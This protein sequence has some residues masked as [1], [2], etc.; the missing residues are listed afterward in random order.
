MR[1]LNSDNP[2]LVEVSEVIDQGSTNLA[3]LSFSVG[4]AGK[5][6]AAGTNSC[7]SIAASALDGLHAASSAAKPDDAS[8]NMSGL[9]AD[10]ASDTLALISDGEPDEEE[11]NDNDSAA[12]STGKDSSTEGDV[13]AT[14]EVL[15]ADLIEMKTLRTTT[16][17]HDDW[18]HRG[19]YLHDLSYHTYTEYIDRM[20]L[21]QQA[22]LEEQIFRFES[23]YVLFRSYGQRIKT[24]ARTPVMEALKFVPPGGSTKEENA[25]YKLLIGSPLRCACAECTAVLPRPSAS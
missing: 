22:P 18:L 1:L 20:R 3:A 17:A 13:D 25:L 21:P 12:E 19:S 11:E 14:T 15:K 23:H 6:D 9:L 16:S 5:L 7:A 2:F 8:T 4:S 24:P 10:T